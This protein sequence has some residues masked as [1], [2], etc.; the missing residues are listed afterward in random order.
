MTEIEDGYKNILAK[1]KNVDKTID[2]QF[3]NVTINQEKLNEA[4]F[5]GQINNV[6]ATKEIE[7]QEEALLKAVKQY[8]DKLLTDLRQNSNSLFLSFEEESKH[9]KG[10]RE[11]LMEQKLKVNKVIQSKDLLEVFGKSRDVVNITPPKVEVAYKFNCLPTF[12]SG[13]TENISEVFGSVQKVKIKPLKIEVKRLFQFDMDS[14]YDIDDETNTQMVLSDGTLWVSNQV[15]ITNLKLEKN[16]VNT[17]FEVKTGSN[18]IAV[19]SSD[20]ILLAD[21]SSTLKLLCKENKQI[22]PTGFHVSQMKITAV[23]VSYNKDI[24]IAGFLDQATKIV[25]MNQTAEA[26]KEY[27]S[28]TNK[29]LLFTLVICITSNHRNNIGIVDITH[30]GRI[31]RIL[32]IVQDNNTFNI[33]TGHSALKSQGIEFKPHDIVTTALDN[34][35]VLDEQ[36]LHILN[37]EGQA[38]TFVHIDQLIPRWPEAIC[39][40]DTSHL[41]IACNDPEESDK[42]NT[43]KYD[44]HYK[45]S[46]YSVDI[47]NW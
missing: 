33:Y 3:V 7:S 17:A 13:K 1:L 36:L 31:G 37:N 5:V 2:Q 44:E 39:V 40:S 6:R 41:Y 20:D 18:S 32:V 16:S 28:D 15:T 34:F 27:Q 9:M 43:D 19:N 12:I 25:V 30:E 24:M 47:S 10:T 11:R 35:V 38:I 8:K 46:V 23:H 21:G 29:K 45:M 22:L 4:K 26:K 42:Y 14:K